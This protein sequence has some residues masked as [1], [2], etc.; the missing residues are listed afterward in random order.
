VLAAGCCAAARSAYAAG[1]YGADR[2]SASGQN[3]GQY[4]AAQPPAAPSQ[5]ISAEEAYSE[6]LQLASGKKDPAYIN[7][8]YE[9]IQRS[10]DRY[11]IVQ[12][13]AMA[14]VTA[15]QRT[16]NR[17]S[18]ARLDSWHMYESATGHPATPYPSVLNDLDTAMSELS[19]VLSNSRS[20][21]DALKTYW[22]GPQGTV[23]TASYA[24]FSDFV[25]KLWGGLKPYW[26]ER[27]QQ[28]QHS[29][30][31]ADFDSSHDDASAWGGLVD[32][33]LS[34]YTSRLGA[35]PELASQLQSFPVERDYAAMVKYYNHSISSDE[36]MVIAR[37]VLTFC[38]QTKGESKVDPRLVMALI[39]AESNFRPSAVSNKG[40]MGLGQL[41]PGTAR[42]LG[43]NDPFDPIQNVYGCVKYLER[44]SYRWRG[45]DNAMDLVL[46]SYNAGAGA[47][48][49][50]GGIPPYTQTRNYVKIVKQNYHS[51]CR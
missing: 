27:K 18:Y 19:Q 6:T 16:G 35:R 38:A 20:L 31:G 11:G 26:A 42:G 29:R 12:E 28:Q 22:C 45:N 51:Y 41:M 43:V 36:A 47:V 40:A 2:Y 5:R 13:F 50:Y 37:A 7:G 46:A 3:S 10:A 8:L 21:D 32:G 48:L 15:E 34:G 33:D 30:Y 39:K 9:R 4:R 17:I 23:N 25:N 44:E 49:R 1:S 24:T 14:V